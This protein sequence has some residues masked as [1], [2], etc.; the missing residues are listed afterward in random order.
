MEWVAQILSLRGRTLYEGTRRLLGESESQK[1]HITDA[2]FDHP[3]IR[4]LGDG[5]QRPSYISSKLFTKVVRDVLASAKDMQRTALHVDQSSQTPINADLARSLRVLSTPSS[6]QRGPAE[7]ASDVA[8]MSLAAELPDESS[9]AEWFDHAMDRLS[10]TYK[11]TTQRW[12][13]AFSVL[14]VVAL[15]ANSIRLATQLW[16]SPTL[17]AY[18][19]ERAKVRLD[20]GAPLESVEYTEPT[21][22]EVSAPARTDSG[23]SPNALLAEE[24]AMLG[25]IFSWSG[26]GLRLERFRTDYGPSLGV[27]AWIGVSA[28]GWAMTALAVS[29]GAPF[30]F[31]TLSKFMRARA[32]GDVPASTSPTEKHTP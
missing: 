8:T 4:N 14:I 6:T 9:V 19:V 7:A 24:Q 26:E 2:V 32:A 31:D 13:L 27:A 12:V 17:R 11:R 10:G 16:Q 29:L 1:A 21:S 30:W 5:K 22:P 28:L 20:Q 23:K 3:L 25:Q 18:M 15:N